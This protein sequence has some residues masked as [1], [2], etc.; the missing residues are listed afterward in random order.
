MLTSA[1]GAATFERL[2]AR[3]LLVSYAFL[4]APTTILLVLAAIWINGLQHP[5]GTA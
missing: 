3:T 4:T 5:E 1:S 2:I